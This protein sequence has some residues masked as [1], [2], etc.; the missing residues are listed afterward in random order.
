M[1]VR[2]SF[3]FHELG[4]QANPIVIWDGLAPVD[5]ALTIVVHVDEDWCYDKVDQRGSDTDTEIMT[6]PEFWEILIYE[7]FSVIAGER[8]AVGLSSVCAQTRPSAHVNPENL[9]SFG[10]S[11]AN[12]F[13]LDDKALR[14]T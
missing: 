1:V 8:E 13:R 6:T 12:S 3:V 7:N 11:S 14:I 10:W 4:T 2:D 5:S 9:H